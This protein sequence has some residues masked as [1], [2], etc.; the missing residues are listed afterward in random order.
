MKKVISIALKLSAIFM[1]IG[2]GSQKASN[3]KVGTA[4]YQDSAVMGID[5]ECGSQSGTTSKDGKFTFEVGKDCKFSLAGIE[6]KKI[7]KDQLADGKK[8]VEN[9]A[10]VASLLQSL[11]ADGNASNGIE[12]T[13]KIKKAFEEQIQKQQTKIETLTQ[14]VDQLKNQINS[15]KQQLADQNITIKYVT[16]EKA[17]EHARSTKAKVIKDLIGGKTVYLVI[18][19][20]LYNELVASRFT[21]DENLSNVKVD[22][23]ID[24]KDNFESIGSFSIEYNPAT[25]EIIREDQT[26][27]MKNYNSKKVTLEDKKTHIE[28]ILFFNKEDAE[29]YANKLKKEHASSSNR[30][31][32]GQS[33]SHE[34]FDDSNSSYENSDTNSSNR[35]SVGH[36]V[37]TLLS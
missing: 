14:L 20:D 3:A 6:L 5:Y 24:W 23:V 1:L 37:A 13:L 18:W 8:V 12:I 17:M 19:N 11:D 22:Q 10:S 7:H 4:Y 29:D 35:G 26:L 36:S 27:V 2:C 9:N 25:D 33:N 32:V 30:D 16:P 31:S 28:A 21:F 34:N 15:L